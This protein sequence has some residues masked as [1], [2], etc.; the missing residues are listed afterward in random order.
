MIVILFVQNNDK[1][2]MKQQSYS[3]SRKL[4]AFEPKYVHV[5]TIDIKTIDGSR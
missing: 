2:S 5:T 1:M 4:D 3:N